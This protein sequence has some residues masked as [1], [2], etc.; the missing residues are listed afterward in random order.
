MF[1]PRHTIESVTQEVVDGLEEGTIILRPEE[2]TDADVE[3]FESMMKTTLARYRRREVALL[4]A[5]IFGAAVSIL[6]ALVQIGEP[7]ARW[8]IMLVPCIGGA[9]MGF[10]LGYKTRERSIELKTYIRVLKMADPS[11]AR[12][13]VL[14]VAPQLRKREPVP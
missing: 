5:S 2:P 3:D 4:T 12:R 7:H 10:V 8:A 13:L 6:I 14:R 11:T 9:L 1:G